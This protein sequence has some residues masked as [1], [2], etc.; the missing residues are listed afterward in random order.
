MKRK[1]KSTRVLTTKKKNVQNFRGKMFRY[2]LL[3]TYR[4]LNVGAIPSKTLADKYISFLQFEMY[5]NKSNGKKSRH[6]REKR[7]EEKKINRDKKIGKQKKK[8]NQK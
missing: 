2:Q 5:L 6:G 3:S 4:D 1:K 8:K 7:K